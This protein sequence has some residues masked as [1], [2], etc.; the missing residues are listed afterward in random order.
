MRTPLGVVV[1]FTIIILVDFYLFFVVRSMTNDSSPKTRTLI[2]AGF[3]TISVLTL[4]GLVMFAY[5]SRDF[6]TQKFRIYLFAILIGIF[7][8]KLVALLFFIVDDV[9]RIIQ[10]IAGHLF[11]KNSDPSDSGGVAISR[12]VFL[13]WLG[14]AAGGTILGSWIYGFSNKYNYVVKRIKLDYKN[15]PEG[16]RGMKVVFISD[17]HSGS[18]T[19]KTKVARG[20]DMIMKEG[21]DLILFGG[22]LV[23]DMALEMKDYM[24]VFNK[25]K[26]PLGVFSVFGNHDYGEYV[27]WPMDGLT[28]EQNLI[29]LEKVHADLGWTLLR[30]RHEVI[31]RNGDRLPIIGVENWSNFSRFPKY[32]DLKKAY[33]G[34]EEF[35]FKLLISHDP[36]HWDAQIRPEF[37]DIDLTLSGHTHGMQFGVEIPGFRWSPVQYMYKEWDGL[38]ENGSQKLYVNPGFG[39]IGYPGRVGILPEIT[40]F[41]F[42]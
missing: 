27:R 13:N 23:N 30:N 37:P 26:A 18:F 15:L 39:F 8:S 20:V 38:Y 21:A 22:D 41:E 32:G 34:T 7:F 40:V 25:L 10:W 5:T 14:L 33:T 42:S 3:W 31:E 29:N 4:L 35:P 19:D 16:F 9:R 12:S 36:S 1:I 17:I 2:Y 24:D 11:F 6:M 28:K